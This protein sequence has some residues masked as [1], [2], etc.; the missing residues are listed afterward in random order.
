MVAPRGSGDTS[1]GNLKGNL[2]GIQ[3]EAMGREEHTVGAQGD[4]Y[5]AGEQ[6]FRDAGTETGNYQVG[7]GPR[8]EDGDA[9][10]ETEN[11]QVGGGPCAGAVV[12]V[13]TVL[14]LGAEG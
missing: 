3:E 9:G 2:A 6:G 4:T 10:A 5:G 14:G 11:G 8:A 13:M 1:Q 7:G 12:V